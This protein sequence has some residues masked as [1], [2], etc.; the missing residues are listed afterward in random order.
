M[1]RLYYSF[2]DRRWVETAIDERQDL[3]FNYD[4]ARLEWGVA[5]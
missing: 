3:K 1:K 5:E 4:V 2:P